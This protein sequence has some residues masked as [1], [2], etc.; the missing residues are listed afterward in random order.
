MLGMPLP[1]VSKCVNH[2]WAAIMMPDKGW[3]YAVVNIQMTFWA[4]WNHDTRKQVRKLAFIYLVWWH[5][6]VIGVV[7]KT[8]ARLIGKD[9]VG[10]RHS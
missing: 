1:P 10:F 6:I 4:N 3:L 9:C 7:M 5:L 8:F 2:N